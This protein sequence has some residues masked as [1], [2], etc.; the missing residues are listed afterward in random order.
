MLGIVAFILVR[1]DGNLD[2]GIISDVYDP[3]IGSLHNS[4]GYFL[5]I[6]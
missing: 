4:R 2:K 3:I 6:Q 5:P 1:D